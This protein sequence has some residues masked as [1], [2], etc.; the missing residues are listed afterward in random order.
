[1]TVFLT[2]IT[3]WLY[4]LDHIN[5]CNLIASGS[6]IKTKCSIHCKCDL[7]Y[8]QLSNTQSH[9]PTT[10]KVPHIETQADDSILSPRVISLTKK[11]HVNF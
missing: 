4:L 10:T 6:I 11:K 3:E 1:M 9:I 8:K 2:E 5:R 7:I